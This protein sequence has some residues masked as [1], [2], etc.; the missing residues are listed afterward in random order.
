MPDELL[1][2]FKLFLTSSLKYIFVLV[3]R[4]MQHRLICFTDMGLK[5]H[6]KWWS[7]GWGQRAAAPLPLLLA[8][9]GCWLCGNAVCELC[10]LQA[11]Q[12]AA[13]LP[14]D[15]VSP[16]MVYRKKSLCYFSCKNSYLGRSASAIVCAIVLAELG[17]LHELPSMLPCNISLPCCPD[18]KTHSSWWYLP[19]G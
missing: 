6:C 1:T 12:P 11:Q 16:Q 14:G 4:K 9:K 7:C 8:G 17:C 15:G 5:L 10:S 2:Y 18:D 19:E 3:T 13:A